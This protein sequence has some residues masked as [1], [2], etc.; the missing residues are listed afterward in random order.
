QAR[1]SLSEN[2]PRW[3][4]SSAL[5]LRSASHATQTCSD[6]QRLV[7]PVEETAPRP[8]S[9]SAWESLAASFRTASADTMAPRAGAS[10]GRPSRLPTIPQ[11]D[12]LSSGPLSY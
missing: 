10:T 8:A 3:Q 6:F 2:G 9:G 1:F 12:I 4:L 5:L 7:V 11:M